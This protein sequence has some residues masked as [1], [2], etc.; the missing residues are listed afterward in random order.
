MTT[1]MANII[2]AISVAALAAYAAWTYAGLPDPMPT[3]WNAAGEVNSTM[4]KPYGVA[5]LFSVPVFSWV[6]LRIIPVISPRGFRTEGFSDVVNV[7]M[8]VTV[9]F[10]S[11]IGIVALLT[12]QGA[13]FNISDFVLGSVG[14]LLMLIGNYMGKIRKN[15]F[16]GIRTP[17]TLA[18]D[19]VWAKTHRLGGWCFVL[20]GLMILGAAIAGI[21][22]DMIIGVVVAAALIPVGYSYFAYRSIE[23]FAPD[24]AA[25]EDDAN[26]VG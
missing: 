3:H 7:L 2:S 15:F 13:L 12:A 17:W 1:R 14:V 9:V 5:V 10:G 11:V 24:P 22:P 4:S 21:N 26:S 19:E 16:I 18:S 23:G 8:A 6:L 20:A 25:E